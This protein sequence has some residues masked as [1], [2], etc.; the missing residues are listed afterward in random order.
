MAVAPAT[1]VEPYLPAEHV[2]PATFMLV[3]EGQLLPF[4]DRPAEV[5]A[6]LTTCPTN[7]LMALLEQAFPMDLRLKRPPGEDTLDPDACPSSFAPSFVTEV[8]SR[9]AA[10]PPPPDAFG[11]PA[12]WSFGTLLDWM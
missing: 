5:S 8:Q 3:P 12:S 9:A 4:V 7:R 6:F 2:E 11:D 1:D 10:P